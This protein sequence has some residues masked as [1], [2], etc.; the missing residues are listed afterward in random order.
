MENNLKTFSYNILKKE[1]QP[2][3]Q[4]YLGTFLAF[5]LFF[6]FFFGN[7]L[8]FLIVLIISVFIFLEKEVEIGDEE[9]NINVAFLEHSFIYG[10]K[11][12]AY[13][14]VSAFTIHDE[15]FGEEEVNL[16][17]S[18]KKPNQQDLFIYVPRNVQIAAVYDIIRKHVKEDRDK[19]LSLTDSIILRFF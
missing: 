18:F 13:R 5:S 6:S 2:A 11:E 10:K 17:F 15:L 1:I 3:G 4:V 19:Q 16:R 14:D 12:Y 7:L 8:F 9:G